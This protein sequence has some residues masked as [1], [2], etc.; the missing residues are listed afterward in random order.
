MT[1]EEMLAAI[2]ALPREGLEEIA[3]FAVGGLWGTG[4]A[5]DANKDV[6]GSDFIDHMSDVLGRVGLTPGEDPEDDK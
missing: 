4:S 6:R 2:R 1:N 3:L 5:Y